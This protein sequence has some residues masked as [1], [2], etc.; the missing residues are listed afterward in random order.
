M[1]GGRSGDVIWM[2]PAHRGGGR[3]AQRSREQITAAAI[4]IADAGG[5]DAVS[6]RAVAAALGTGA[7]SLYRYVETR[8]DLLDLM[9]DAA[10]G[11]YAFGAPT[12]D[13]L[14]DLVAVGEQA[15]SLMGRHPWLPALV[16]TRPVL[17]PNG[18]VLLEHVLGLLAPCPAGLAAKLDAFALLNAV[19]ALFALNEQGG[20]PGTARSAAYLAHVLAGGRHPRLAELLAPAPADL[21]AAGGPAGPEGPEGEDAAD[22]YSGIMTRI[23]SGLLAGGGPPSG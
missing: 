12:G 14:A 13:W 8:D 19:T 22:R 6:M 7:A 18:V 20:G 9:T 5:L 10:G 17:G 3:P 11:G 23:L 16:I 2:R 4:A 15:R 21:A 1:T